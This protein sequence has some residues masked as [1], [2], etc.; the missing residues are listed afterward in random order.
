MRA[1]AIAPLV[2]AGELVG[3]LGSMRTTS[4]EPY[5]LPEL[6]LLEALAER[7]AL[8]IADA[9]G[10]PRS[11]DAADYEAIYRHNLDGV[12]ITT[13]D[14][15][16]LTANPAA[17]RILQL[18]EREIVQGGRDLIVVADDPRLLPALAARALS[19]HVRA[20]LALRRGDGSV[21][22]ADVSSTI[23]ATLDHGTRAV[24]IFRDVSSEVAR[25]ELVAARVAELE[26][27]VDHDPLTGLRNRRGFAIAAEQAT[28]MADRQGLTCHLLFVDVD[29]LKRRNDTEGHAAGDAAILAVARAIARATRDVDVACRL[30]GDEFLVLIVD[31]PGGDVDLVIERIRHELAADEEAPAGVTFSTGVSERPPLLEATLSE[32]IDAADRDMYQ[33]RVLRR[34]RRSAG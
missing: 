33:N 4:A 28:A 32:V 20:E 6:R 25:R 23:Y 1:L 26:Q 31:A 16:I 12:L 29:D 3:T 9:L 18:T 2:A 30:G 14:G 15:H 11:I 34:L 5:K 17:C 22:P 8:A 7:A 21:F 19:G 10:G 13:P 27:V 24:V